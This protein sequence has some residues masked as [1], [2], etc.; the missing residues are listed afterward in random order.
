MKRLMALIVLTLVSGAWNASWAASRAESEVACIESGNNCKTACM[1]SSG[2]KQKECIDNCE[3]RKQQCL[4]EV[5]SQDS[6]NG[7]GRKKP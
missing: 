5:R 3:R 6:R 1:M 7:G 2:P 4:N